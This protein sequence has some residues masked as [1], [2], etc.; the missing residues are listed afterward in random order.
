MA[1]AV[2]RI[3]DYCATIPFWTQTLIMKMKENMK[4]EYKHGKRF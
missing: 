2:I 3:F 4:R 1:D